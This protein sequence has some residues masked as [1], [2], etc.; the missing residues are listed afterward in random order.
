M[1]LKYPESI[2]LEE[3]WYDELFLGHRDFDNSIFMLKMGKLF[4]NKRKRMTDDCKK[5][6][7][8]YF[9]M[10]TFFSEQ[11][12]LLSDSTLFRYII[13]QFFGE[14]VMKTTTNLSNL[15]NKHKIN[16]ASKIFL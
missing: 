4:L 6:V 16:K 12:M 13:S 5:I 2:K 15:S 8:D 1:P 9:F 10:Y 7:N 3:F 14:K 11:M